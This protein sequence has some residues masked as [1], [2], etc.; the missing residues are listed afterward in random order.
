[1]SEAGLVRECA[2][3]S[4]HASTQDGRLKRIRRRETP[5][6]PVSSPWV[7]AQRRRAKRK[8]R[9]EAGNRRGAGTRIRSSGKQKSVGTHRGRAS[10][11]AERQPA[12][13]RSSPEQAIEAADAGDGGSPLKRANRDGRGR[14]ARK[15]STAPCTT[16]GETGARSETVRRRHAELSKR[17]RGAWLCLTSQGVGSEQLKCCLD[18][19]KLAQATDTT[20]GALG[21]SSIFSLA[22]WLLE[23]MAPRNGETVG[24]SWLSR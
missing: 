15:R 21:R 20:A 17:R 5:G 6:P 13:G 7:Q 2:E 9:R 11:V 22:T 12:G 18:Q 23:Q 19:R 10:Q 1:V 24:R 4:R 3:E 8:L 16:P 14:R